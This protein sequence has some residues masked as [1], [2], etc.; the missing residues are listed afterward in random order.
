LRGINIARAR[1][2]VFRDVTVVEG[3]IN[4][5][6]REHISIPIASSVRL[7][8]V[9]LYISPDSRIELAR[10]VGFTNT[11]HLKTSTCPL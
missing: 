6:A 1:S 5:V 8:L 7:C 10:L 4:K 3:E 2:A 9:V 11:R